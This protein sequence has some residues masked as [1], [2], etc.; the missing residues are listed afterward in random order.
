M[1]E[2]NELE[3]TDIAIDPEIDVDFDDSH[4]ISAYIEIWFDVDKKF[5][6]NINNEDDTW[7]NMYGKYNPFED[8]LRIECEIARDDSSKSFL[9][10]PTDDEAT[11]IKEL[12]AEKLQSQYGETPREFCGRFLGDAESIKI[13]G[14]Q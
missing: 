6:T 13:G 1:R 2:N 5:G 11:L 9:Y 8:T 14:I 12:I 4:V 10:Q 3:R 7:L